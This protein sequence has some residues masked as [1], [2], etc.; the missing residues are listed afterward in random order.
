MKSL[1]FC[2]TVLIG[3][4]LIHS[5][6]SDESTPLTAVE[7]T[8]LKKSFVTDPYFMPDTVI[9]YKLFTDS[10]LLTFHPKAHY[11][12]WTLQVILR[13]DDRS[14]GMDLGDKTKVRVS[15]N[16]IVWK[17]FHISPDS[18]N[19]YYPELF[20]FPIMKDNYLVLRKNMDN[21]R[22]F[23][24]DPDKDG[25]LKP[26][27]P[28]KRQ[29]YIGFRMAILPKLK[30]KEYNYCWELLEKYLGYNPSTTD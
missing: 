26:W 30:K 7:K 20:G 27:G 17:G 23:F 6:T 8:K 25:I 19:L 22:M 4:F 1:A 15:G 24:K 13:T 5:C 9:H 18:V 14:A 21:G 29:N 16:S 2:F 11:K 28:G 12:Q 10:L 3:T